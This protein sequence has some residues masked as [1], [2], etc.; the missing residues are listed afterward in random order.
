M[1]EILFRVASD[2]ALAGVE[3]PCPL[4]ADRTGLFLAPEGLALLSVPGS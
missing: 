1:S 4:Q 2:I 3:A